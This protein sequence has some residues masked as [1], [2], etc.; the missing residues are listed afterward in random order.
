MFFIEA[1]PFL[2]I[3]LF[4]LKNR[5]LLSPVQ[6]YI[7]LHA[8]IWI[9]LIAI[10]NDNVGTATRLRPVA[11]LLIIIVLP[12]LN[13]IAKRKAVKTLKSNKV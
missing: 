2:F 12:I 13:R 8:F 7:L 11:W 4:L 5:K 9:S 10:T 6:S 1:L 3:L